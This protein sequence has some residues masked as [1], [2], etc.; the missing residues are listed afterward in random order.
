MQQLST[1]QSNEALTEL[2]AR[3]AQRVLGYF[4]R[5]FNGD[6]D[7]AQDFV[8]ELFLRILEK[9]QQFDTSRKF[10]TW[11]FSIAA[12][13]CKTEFR[14]VPEQHFSEETTAPFWNDDTQTKEVFRRALEEALASLDEEHRSVFVLRYMSQLSLKE[15]SE[16]KEIPLGTV[17][18]RLFNATKKMAHRMQA[19]KASGADIFKLS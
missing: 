2:H 1:Q 6:T 9:H 7:K 10:Y 18:S 17:K 13:M 16:A 8:Q 11:M 5:M 3:Y 19:F 4:I 15:I 14:K 12:N